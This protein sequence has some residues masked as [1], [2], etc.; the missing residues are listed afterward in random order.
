MRIECCPNGGVRCSSCGDS[1]G[2]VGWVKLNK[3]ESD[4]LKGVCSRGIHFSFLFGT[5]KDTDKA[6]ALL[7]KLEN[8]NY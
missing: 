6:Q 1:D 3:E 5:Q 4:W 8:I 7:T 2:L